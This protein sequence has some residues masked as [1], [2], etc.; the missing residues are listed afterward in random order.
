M[1]RFVAA[2]YGTVTVALPLVLILRGL[3]TATTA[4]QFHKISTWIKL[5]M[6]TGILSMLFFKFRI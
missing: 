3:Y 2:L 4:P 6:L 5:V 1:G